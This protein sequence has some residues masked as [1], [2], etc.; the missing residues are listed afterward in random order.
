MKINV[1]LPP[2]YT[3]NKLIKKTKAYMKGSYNKEIANTVFEGKNKGY[4]AYIKDDTI[5][6]EVIN[7]NKDNIIEIQ[8]YLEFLFYK[9]YVG[10]SFENN[11]DICLE[12]K[13]VECFEV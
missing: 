9:K 8:K 3:Y 7:K 11:Q 1:T 2:N 12:L 5:Q 13:N 10:I 4:Y 6:I